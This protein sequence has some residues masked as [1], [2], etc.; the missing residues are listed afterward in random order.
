MKDIHPEIMLRS[1]KNAE[2]LK[3][4]WSRACATAQDPRSLYEHMERINLEDFHRFNRSDW[5]IK[6]LTFMVHML[7]EAKIAAEKGSDHVAEFIADC[8]TFPLDELIHRVEFPYSYHMLSRNEDYSHLCQMFARLLMGDDGSA[9][10]SEVISS[11]QT[12]NIATFSYLTWKMAGQKTYTIAPDLADALKA[13]T[14]KKYPTDLL[15]APSPSMYVEF[16][17]GAFEFTTYSDSVTPSDTGYI[18]LPVEGAYILEDASPDGMRLWRVVVICQYYS[19]PSKAVHVNHYYIPLYDNHPVDDCLADALAMMKGDKV[20]EVSIP[21]NE[22]GKIGVLGG[23]HK[24]WDKKI[25]DSAEEIFR[26]LMN[27]VIY[28]THGDADETLVNSSSEYAKYRSRMLAAKG[29][30][31][32]SLKDHLKKMNNGTRVLLGKNY[33]IKR[34]DHADRAAGEATGRHI[35]VRTLVSGHWRNQPCGIGHLERKVIWI[36]PFWRGPEAAPLTEKRAV[37]K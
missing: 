5:N 24:S 28:I 22:I 32:E 34:W 10:T 11:I 16:P 17:P 15:R 6:V 37:V 1:H 35:T 31:R 14:L 36:E 19:R 12:H 13:T 26:F 29:K 21:G 33:S 8:V 9:P 7:R 27:V 20:C 30:K 3:R 18:S 4:A 23:K 2:G 25:V